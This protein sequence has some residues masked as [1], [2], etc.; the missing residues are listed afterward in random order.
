MYFN[1]Q[2]LSSITVQ[3]YDLF[4]AKQRMEYEMQ[5]ANIKIKFNRKR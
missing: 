4:T 2:E 3:V 5:E 1:T